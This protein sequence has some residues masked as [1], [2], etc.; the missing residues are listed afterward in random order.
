MESLEI[1]EKCFNYCLSEILDYC[2][3]KYINFSKPIVIERNSIV[4]TITG[5][6]G[7]YFYYEI[8]KCNL[9][10]KKSLKSLT[11][12]DDIDLIIKIYQ[13][14]LYNFQRINLYSKTDVKGERQTDEGF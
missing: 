7:E 13:A 10:I 9:V 5:C 14:C 2:K 4:M 3:D 12:Q 1:I 8:F 11:W 6:Y